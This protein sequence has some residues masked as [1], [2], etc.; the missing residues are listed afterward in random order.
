LQT[1]TQLQHVHI[2]PFLEAGGTGDDIYL[3]TAYHHP[4]L[5]TLRAHLEQRTTQRL[6]PE[7]A[8]TLLEQIGQALQYAHYHHVLHRQLT[9]E[10]ILLGPAGAMVSDFGL[11]YAGDTTLRKQSQP[12][13]LHEQFAYLA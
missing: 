3:V 6:P 12:M 4:P 11:V 1:L 13:K 2:L 8:L 5:E 9:P 10:R 7:E